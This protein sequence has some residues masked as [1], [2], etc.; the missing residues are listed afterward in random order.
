MSSTN[1][2][3]SECN[4]TKFNFDAYDK[5]EGTRAEFVELMRAREVSEPSLMLVSKKNGSP[6]PCSIR[7]LDSLSTIG[8]FPKPNE[9]QLKRD[10]RGRPSLK[11]TAEH[12]YRY[13]LHQ[14]LRKSGQKIEGIASLMSTLGPKEIKEKVISWS[15][16]FDTSELL[17]DWESEERELSEG[18]MRLGR[19][20]GNI[21]IS[22]QTR[23]AILP[24]LHL[25]AGEEQLKKLSSQDI[26]LLTR[27]L[28]LKLKKH[29]AL[30]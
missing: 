4:M 7:R 27:A 29:L 1:L 5:F 25:Y 9:D 10:G 14:R 6:I 20:N 8:V 17:D 16:K 23:F 11:M 15:I 18:L 26:D 19:E 24:W 22:H 28:N 30:V 21:L 12:C 3:F 13:E 2:I